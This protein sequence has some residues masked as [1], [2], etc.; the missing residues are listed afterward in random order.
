M[1]GTTLTER[2]FKGLMPYEEA[3]ALF[4]FGR[5]VDCGVIASNLMASRLTILYG[6]SGV[7]KSSVLDAGVVHHVR[8]LAQDNLKEISKPEFAVVVHRSWRDDPGAGLLAGV[9]DSVEQTLGRRFDPVPLGTTLADALAI[10]AERLDGTLLIILDQFEEYFLYHPREDGPGTFA[11]EFPAAVNRPDLR[12]NVL[13][14]LRED[15]LAKLDRFE[16]KI[17]SL[18]DNYLRLAPLDR[19]AAVE[20]LRGPIA[21]Y[22]RHHEGQQVTIEPKLIDEVL[23]QVKAG[24]VELVAAG[25]GVV[26]GVGDWDEPRDIHIET[27]YLQLVMTRLWN[28][29]QRLGSRTLRWET[30][31]QKV[32]GARAIVRKHFDDEMGRLSPTERD[33]ASDVLPYLV[34]PS[35]AKIAQEPAF[36]AARTGRPA[37]QVEAVLRR[38]AS[39]EG[40]ILRKVDSPH[41]ADSYEIFHD[42]LARVILDYVKVQDAERAKERVRRQYF[43]SAGLAAG[44]VLALLL[45]GFA[46]WQWGEAKR[47]TEHSQRSEAEAKKQT[48]IAQTAEEE[49]RNKAQRANSLKLAAQAI[50]HQRDQFDLALLLSLEACRTEDTLETRG[51]LLSTLNSNPQLSQF[52]RGHT[53]AVYGVAFSPDGGTLAS[54][55]ADK[56]VI[57]WDAKTRTPRGEPLAGHTGGVTSVAFSPDGG[58]LA[59]AAADKTVILWD[60]KTRTRIGEP[61]AGHTGGVTSVAFSP[62]GGT[63]ASASRD[64]TVILWD[65][66]TRTPLGAPLAG[67]TGGVT[68]VAFS[69]DGGTLASAADDKTVILWDVKTRTRRGEPLAGHT[70]EVY[71]VAFSPDGGTLAS[72]SRDKTVILWDVKTRTPLGE[73]L[74]GHTNTVQSVAFSPDGGTLASASQDG[75]VILWDFKMRTRRGEPL[76]GTRAIVW[77]VAFSPDGG[78]LASASQDGTVI[79]WDF[80]TRTRLGTPLAGHTAPCT[81]WRSAP[82]AAR[83]PPPPPTRPSSSGTPRRARGGASPSPGTRAA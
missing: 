25:R 27:S 64:N 78:T 13:L 5:E 59:S 8:Q 73:P 6:P 70:W 62:D 44:L 80:K 36:I 40:R 51:S 24:A 17:R 71:G 9:Q 29:E 11:T 74:A 7:G 34:T 30:F 49:A 31:I 43:I 46:W 18:F 79:L 50:A 1:S 48:R 67:H 42:V 65:A 15:A 77:D 45:S 22:N 72:A 60:A 19:E 41:H 12:V 55:A 26:A 58:T 83:S 47:A 10:W 28:E 16:G 20:A 56:T 32:G 3:D 66:K 35:G 57:L 14:S 69:P 61:L 4:F 21:E 53:G 76:A 39:Q 52:L 37:D 33:V 82:M 54:A 75:T 23:A 38:L 2:P 63:L 81:A 68:S